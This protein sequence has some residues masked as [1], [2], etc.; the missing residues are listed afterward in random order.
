M[1]ETE[2]DPLIRPKRNVRMMLVMMMMMMMMMMMATQLNRFSRVLP[3]RLDL[4]G[5]NTP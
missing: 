1:G 4:Q 2:T 5:K 3:Q